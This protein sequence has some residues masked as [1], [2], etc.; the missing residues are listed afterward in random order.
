MNLVLAVPVKSTR[1]A[2]VDSDICWTKKFLG[3]QLHSFYFPE[4]RLFVQNL[5][6]FV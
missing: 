3:V 6:F 4:G 5:N 2:A 1:T